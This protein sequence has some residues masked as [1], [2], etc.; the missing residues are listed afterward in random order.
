MRGI[1]I[2]REK[3]I[4]KEARQNMSGVFNNFND[5]TICAVATAMSDSGIGV[6]RVSGREAVSICD[7]IYR[8]A[9]MEQTLKKHDILNHILRNPQQMRISVIT[10]KNN[11]LVRIIIKYKLT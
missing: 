4:K 8:S 5:D 7:K 6:I 9:K 1:I 11:Q 3:L 10:F 2:C